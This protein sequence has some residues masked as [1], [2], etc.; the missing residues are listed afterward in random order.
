MM[1]QILVINK[2]I[3]TF[4]TNNDVI[5]LKICDISAF[6]NNTPKLFIKSCKNH[7]NVLPY[8][9]DECDLKSALKVAIA[10]NNLDAMTSILNKENNPESYYIP[11]IRRAAYNNNI[12]VVKCIFDNINCTISCDQIIIDA[13][14]CDNLD[15]AKYL[16]SEN[17]DDAKLLVYDMARDGR[18]DIL[19]IFD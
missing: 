14:K 3:C 15:I 18:I 11:F 10:H 7:R 2:L 19:K 4:L 12:D 9:T 13:C 8:Y 1:F 5:H 16:I 6:L 17:A